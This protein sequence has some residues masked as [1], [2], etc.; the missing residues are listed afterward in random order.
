MAPTDE[1]R[2]SATGAVPRRQLE[3]RVEESFGWHPGTS[4]TMW[5][6]G[7]SFA[8]ATKT[9][10]GLRD[11]YVSVRIRSGSGS[12]FTGNAT[13]SRRTMIDGLDTIDNAIWIR[14]KTLNS[15][16]RHLLSALVLRFFPGYETLRLL[17]Y[18]VAKCRS[19]QQLRNRQ[20]TP[21]DKVFREHPS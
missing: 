2:V 20:V 13:P 9:L 8:F 12:S 3:V 5:A 21:Y 1:K 14:A 11:R 4:Q 7:S 17:P 15:R 10:P 6:I 16:H 18:T 19:H